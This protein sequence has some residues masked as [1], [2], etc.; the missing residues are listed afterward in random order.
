MTSTPQTPGEQLIYLLEE[1]RKR[2]SNS[3]VERT[4][5]FRDNMGENCPYYRKSM[6][7]FLERDYID[8]KNLVHKTEQLF[9]LVEGNNGNS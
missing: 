7:L 8:L 3:G 2:L 4:T 6:S 9:N 1:L 5:G